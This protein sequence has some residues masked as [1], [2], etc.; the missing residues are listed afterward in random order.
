MTRALTD[1]VVE[2]L[3]DRRYIGRG[4]GGKKEGV[5]GSD[6]VILYQRFRHI[7][8]SFVRY[9][10]FSIYRIER[11]LPFTHPCIPGH[12]RLFFT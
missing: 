9:V 12:P 11:V 6:K 8:T 2:L 1:V 3:L 10:V 4:P 5:G 7:D